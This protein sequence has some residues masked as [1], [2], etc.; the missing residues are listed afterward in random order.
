M[1][2]ATFR[3][4]S[5][6]ECQRLHE[7]SLQILE[8]TGV[9]FRY[10]PALKYF[11]GTGARIDG[12]RVRIPGELV[13]EALRTVP[14]SWVV[15]SRGRDEVLELKDGKTYFGTGSDCLYI[16]DLASGKR[17]R[18]SAFDVEDLSAMCELLPNTDFV[19]SMVV[20]EDVPPEQEVL[21]QLVAMLKGTRKPL[22]LAPRDGHS[23][24]L[25]K[26]AAGLC[27]EAESLIVYTMPSPPLMHDDLDL[28]KVINSAA[29]DIPLVCATNA[30]LASTAP[31][32]ITAVAAVGNAEI[33]SALVLHQLVRPG[34]P[35][36][37]GA[38]LDLLDMR[39]MINPYVSPEWVIGQQSQCDVAHHYGLPSFGY[40]GFSDSK[41][42]DE[43]WAAES[44]LTALAGALCR[45]TLMH[46]VGYLE[47][48]LQTSYEAIV[49]GDELVGFARSVLREVPVDEESLA[50]AEILAVGPG[51]HHL[52][53]RYTRGRYRDVWMPTLID[54]ASHGH[55]EAAGATTLG[56]RVRRK[57]QQLRSADRPFS[58]DAETVAK[59]GALLEQD[60]S[61]VA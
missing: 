41:V 22:L 50:L 8:T 10:E 18:G 51:G 11:A 26:E 42:L 45:G 28:S 59:L 57:V 44:A 56:Q 29:L 5:E 21:V 3:V 61:T 52:G 30:T 15:K 34:A 27:G 39:T 60:T 48:G 38:G 7:A 24:A 6:E 55:W 53:T 4:W 46:D 9:E 1:G 16:R 20:P 58:L 13:E 47:S 49:L 31:A 17:R 37:Y 19:M 36:V 12:T 23:L 43:Q 35:F 32:S 33:L 25:M 14:R 2:R 54:R 40:A